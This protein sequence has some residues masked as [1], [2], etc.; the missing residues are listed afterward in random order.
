MT[1]PIIKLVLLAAIVLVA[2]FA[3]RGSTKAY[4]RVVW[5]GYVVGILA[6]AAVSIVFPGSL[7]WLAHK[8][9]VGRGADLLLY[10]LVVTFLLVSV[11]LFRRMEQLE[12][13]YIG[14]ARTMAV[15]Q[16]AEDEPGA[17]SLGVPRDPG[18]TGNAT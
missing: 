9:G 6:V 1:Q 10:V 5:R 14:L 2:L 8:V 15:N 7:T 4:H 12:R 18:P 13:K 16:A 17:T 11:I 3:L